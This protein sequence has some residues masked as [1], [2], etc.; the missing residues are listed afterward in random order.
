[1]TTF[2][3]TFPNKYAEAFEIKRIDLPEGECAYSLPEGAI[4][5]AVEMLALGTALCAREAALKG[6]KHTGTSSARVRRDTPTVEALDDLMD[7]P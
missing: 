5:T 3:V 2:L 1:M 7:A 6:V 4:L